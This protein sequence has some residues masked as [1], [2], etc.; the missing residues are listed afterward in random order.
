MSESTRLEQCPSGTEQRVAEREINLQNGA[1]NAL[2]VRFYIRA[3]FS[4]IALSLVAIFVFDQTI[5]DAD[6]KKLTLLDQ[7]IR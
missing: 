2:K 6:Y 5:D 1:S 4:V 3:L 7:A